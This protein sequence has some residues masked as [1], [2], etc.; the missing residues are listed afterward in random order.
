MSLD[1]AEDVVEVVG[2]AGGQLANRFHLLQL[3]QLLFELT[4]FGDVHED[5]DGPG[6]ITLLIRDFNRTVGNPPFLVLARRDATVPLPVFD[7]AGARSG[8]GLLD[9]QSDR[10]PA[11]GGF[12][13]QTFPQPRRHFLGRVAG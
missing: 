3:S 2:H 8:N 9:G 10:L 11:H 6:G 1:D 7:L 5:A 12:L 13:H 4:A